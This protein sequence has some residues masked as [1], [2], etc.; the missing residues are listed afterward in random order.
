MVREDL[1]LKCTDLNCV[2]AGNTEHL[3]CKISTKYG[4]NA[5]VVGLIY[6]PSNNNQEDDSSLLIV[7]ER[8]TI[9]KQLL[10]LGHFS[11]PGICWDIWDAQCGT[12]QKDFIK[13]INELYWLQ[14]VNDV[15]R[16]WVNNKPSMLD[17]VF[18]R[19]SKEI[20]YLNFNPCLGKSDHVVIVFSICVKELL[21]HKKMSP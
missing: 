21:Q 18:T 8:R 5:I 3:W 9:Q 15:T 12:K 13:T 20:N 4:T 1:I 10:V 14:N 17:L 2:D 6:I 11:Y 16:V 7:A 19:S